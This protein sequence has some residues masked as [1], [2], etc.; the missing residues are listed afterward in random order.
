MITNYRFC[1]SFMFEIYGS[2]VD[3]PYKFIE[4]SHL[5]AYNSHKQTSCNYN[6]SLSVMLDKKCATFSLPRCCSYQC[7]FKTILQYSGNYIC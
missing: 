7:S 6:L 5:F 4:S 2:K 3:S 1:T